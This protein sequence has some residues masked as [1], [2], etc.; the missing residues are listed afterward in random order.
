[1]CVKCSGFYEPQDRK[2]LANTDGQ[3]GYVSMCVCV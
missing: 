3:K 2:I 1:M